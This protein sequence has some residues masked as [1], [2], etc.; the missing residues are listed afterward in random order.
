MRS[1]CVWGEIQ[2]FTII[3][4]FILAVFFSK[5]HV[6]LFYE[7]GV[8][9]DCV[10]QLMP[11]LWTPCLNMTMKLVYPVFFGGRGGF[12]GILGEMS[13][14]LLKNRLDSVTTRMTWG[15]MQASSTF[16]LDHAH[17]LLEEK[18][19]LLPGN[20]SDVSS[21]INLNQIRWCSLIIFLL[22]NTAC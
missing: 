12:C 19:V 18:R 13:C 1:L 10:V 14:S 22:V 7:C 8:C 9:W 17:N 5:C 4:W 21:F 11:L 20:S 3:S 2:T 6:T 16:W 15:I